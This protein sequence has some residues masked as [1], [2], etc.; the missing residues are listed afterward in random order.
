MKARIYERTELRNKRHVFKDRFEAGRML[1]EMLE[2]EFKG[3]QEAIVLAIPAGGVPVGI[4]ISKR[5]LIPFELMIVRKIQ[6]PGNTE[7]GFGA[8]S[9]DGSV[10]LN[11]ELLSYLR[12]TER[13][14]EEQK[15]MV[16]KDLEE[17]DKLFRGSRP[18]PD[19]TGRPVIL[20][21]DGLA[22]GYT[23]MASIHTARNKGARSVTV[24]VPTAPLRSVER[25]QNLVE[26]L[27][28]PI[29]GKAAALPWPTP[30]PTGMTS[31]DK[32]S[33]I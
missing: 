6:I 24:A 22:S 16:K 8:M 19:L 29:S 27:F 7:A 25:M 30:I 13:Q 9:K 17:R 15:A 32:K 14:I 5:L 18:F 2:P 23:M 33:W 3:V 28:A 21:D 10:F 26:R 1:A 31:A 4:E 20:A 12:L 11:D